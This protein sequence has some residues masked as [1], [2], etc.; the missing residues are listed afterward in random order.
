MMAA[1]PPAVTRRDVVPWD[2]E[3]MKAIADFLGRSEGWCR[4]YADES[5]DDPLPVHRYLGRLVARSGALRAWQLR[6]TGLDDE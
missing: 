3:G 6:Q 1:G 2:L 4:R 5:L